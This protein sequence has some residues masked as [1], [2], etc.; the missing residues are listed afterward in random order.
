M[1]GHE[2]E[3]ESAGEGDVR[4]KLSC[5]EIDYGDG[6]DSK[7]QGDDA[8]ISFWFAERIKRVGEDEKEG[9]VKI[10]WVFFVEI[11][12]FLKAKS[13]IIQCIDLVYPEGFSVEG[14]ES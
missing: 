8:E 7:D 6:E 5:K 4:R 2:G 14:V 13:R 12:L 1:V 11:Y 9:R 10:S 3:G